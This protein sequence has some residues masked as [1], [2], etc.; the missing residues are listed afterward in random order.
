LLWYYRQSQE[1]EE[2]SSSDLAND[3]QE[4]GFPRP[5]PTRLRDSLRRSQLSV[6]GRRPGSFRINLRY[7]AELDEQY[8]EL[9]GITRV[10]VED[11]VL[12]FEWVAGTRSYL[13][14]MV[15][16]I[17]GSYQFGF[18]DCCAVL[19]RRLVESLIIDVY[20]SSGRHHEIQNQGVFLALDGLIAFI[21]SDNHLVLARNSPISMREIKQM[22]DTAAHDRVYMTHK[23]DLDDAMPRIRRTVRELLT[24]SGIQP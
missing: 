8:S 9:I 16:Q 20:I 2:R 6:A 17:N 5:H 22:G 7:L 18:Y 4:E 19:I 15:R 1:Y 24:L 11:T 13:E 12:P 3:L 23:L 21:S 14:G 10:D